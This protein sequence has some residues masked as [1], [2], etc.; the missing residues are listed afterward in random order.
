MM[1]SVAITEGGNPTAG[2][3]MYPVFGNEMDSAKLDKS[4]YNL[5]QHW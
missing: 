2:L 3:A 1:L 4:T 5:V